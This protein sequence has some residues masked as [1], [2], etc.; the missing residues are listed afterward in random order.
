LSGNT[1]LDR[2]KRELPKLQPLAQ[3]AADVDVTFM[4]NQ[5][6]GYYGRLALWYRRV[7]Q[8]QGLWL[9]PEARILRHKGKE[10]LLTNREFELLQFPLLLRLL[11]R[12][13]HGGLQL[14]LSRVLPLP[15]GERRSL[16]D[17]RR[18]S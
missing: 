4:E 9:D 3:K 2:V 12:T 6:A 14:T 5:M 15:G 10:A 13:G 11:H 7:W 1:G 16:W 18:P 17:P 8:L